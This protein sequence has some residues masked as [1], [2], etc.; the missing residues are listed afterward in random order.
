[1]DRKNTKKRKMGREREEGGREREDA[2]HMTKWIF[3]KVTP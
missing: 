1:M 2:M 3:M